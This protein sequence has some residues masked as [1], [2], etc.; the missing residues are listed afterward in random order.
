MLQITISW[1]QLNRGNPSPVSLF[2]VVRLF[3][4][5]FTGGE[6]SVGYALGVF[7]VNHVAVWRQVSAQVTT[8]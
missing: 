7:C 6:A 5:E 4:L 8:D 3:H 2:E 1:L